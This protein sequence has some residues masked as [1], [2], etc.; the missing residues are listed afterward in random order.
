MEEE[1]MN[2]I[3]QVWSKKKHL[4]KDRWWFFPTVHRHVNKI[5]C[6]EP[7]DGASEGLNYK[8]KNLGFKS[9]HGVSVGFGDGSKEFKLMNEGIVNKF[10]LFELSEERI[11]VATENAE[12]YGL[13]DRIQIIKGDYNLHEFDEDVDF[14]HWNNSLHHMLNVG[15]AVKWSFE[16]LVNG[17]L[18]YMDDFVGPSRFQ[19]TDAQLQLGTRI[20]HILPDTYLND[21]RKPDKLLNRTVLRP[22]SRLIEK[23]DPSEAAD[24]SAILDY[25]NK[26]FPDA[27]ISLTGGC[28]Y[29]PVL[30]DVFSNIDE[31]DEKDKTIL[32]LLLI[33]DDLATNSGVETLYATALAIKNDNILKLIKRKIRGL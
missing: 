28:I 6:G 3:D 10:T 25:I 24:S 8:L 30:N 16:I 9:E 20:R 31:S 21:T 23:G 26:Y 32:E 4:T 29:N 14:V 1:Y 7:L 12:S 19:W 2:I 13:T 18:F 15:E 33:I 11:K 22:D 27:D 5:V 17:G